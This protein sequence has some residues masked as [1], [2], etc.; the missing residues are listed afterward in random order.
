M[1]GIAGYSGEFEPE[2]L[3]RMNRA[4]A[5]RGPDDAGV[6]HDANRGVGLA[7]RRLS[8][9]DLSPRGHQPM[10]DATRTVAIVYNGEL[11][12]FRE[13]RSELAA[14]GY[15]FESTSDTEVLLNLYLRDG[16]K[17]LE[18]LNGIFAFALWDTRSETLLVARDGAGVKP[19]YYSET[20]RGLI[21]ASELKSLLQ[22]SSVDRSLDGCAVRDHLLYLWCPSPRTMLKSVR[23]L[24]PGHALI[25]REGR[26]AK[27]WRFYDLPYEEELVDWPTGDAVVQVRKYLTRAVERQLVSDVPVG[28]FLSGGLDSSGIVAIAQRRL[29]GER[30][31]CFTIGFESPEAVIEGMAADLPYAR[32]VAEHVGVDLH[33]IW[34]GPEMVDDLPK[35]IF[36]LDEPQ[37]DPAPI[38]ALY[39]T[40]LAREHG[41]KVL[42]SG[43][44]GDDIFTGYRRHYALQ[45]ES[46][47][48]W[49]PDTA[50][51]RLRGLSEGISPTSELRRRVSKALRYADLEGDA[52]IQSYFHWI[53]PNRI[54]PLFGEAVRSDL[55]GAPAHPVEAALAGLPDFVP[56]LNRML[57]LEGKF[58][59]ADHNLNYVDKVSMANGVEVRVPFLDPELMSL[60]ARLPVDYKQRGS[61]GKWVLRKAMEGYLPHDVI[62]RS[63]TGF[64]APLRHWL[65]NQLR[66]LVE[67][68]LSAESLD[69][70][71]LFDPE[72]VRQLVAL[73][74][75]RRVDAAYT[76]FSMIC[77]ELWCRMFV[78]RPTPETV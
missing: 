60:A 5:H 39:S 15:R 31:Q 41:I 45:L 23:K 11:Y 35:M 8:I 65:R 55:K 7:H 2:L 50:R 74:A 73:N 71:G 1:C 12:N 18:K 70:R 10:W 68:V 3:D 46:L 32:R 9:I 76:I 38:N 28:A 14:Q 67:D 64:G 61:L 63:K 25:V 75:E 42:L 77:I 20:P 36:H 54:E 17:M 40:R 43:A 57:Y 19:L 4:M 48:D 49:L 66:P 30:M 33:T 69:R 62:Y 56:A 58:F 29:V 22:E 34:V 16:E 13:L 51:A 44:G 47:W 24:E 78:D 59:L 6:W 52:R 53:A 27:H 72:G 21:F 37:A 26:I